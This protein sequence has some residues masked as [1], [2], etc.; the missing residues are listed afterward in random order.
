MAAAAKIPSEAALLAGPALA[1]SQ[2]LLDTLARLQGTSKL[3]VGLSDDVLSL[4]ASITQVSTVDS[5]SWSLLDANA[6][7]A[8]ANDLNDCRIACQHSIQCIEAWTGQSASQTKAWQSR[9][10]VRLFRRGATKELSVQL[11]KYKG[12]IDAVRQ[13]MYVATQPVVS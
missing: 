12:R 11:L 8:A 6:A 1:A 5:F 4:V 2:L 3:F 7:R 13:T 9:V 10:Y